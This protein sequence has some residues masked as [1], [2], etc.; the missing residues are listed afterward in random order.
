MDTHGGKPKN[1]RADLALPGIEPG[2]A[3]EGARG[4]QAR[5][6]KSRRNAAMYVRGV[7]PRAQQPASPH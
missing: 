5:A 1:R 7:L 3:L 2:P 6:M 4:Y